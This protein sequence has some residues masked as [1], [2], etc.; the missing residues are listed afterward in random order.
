[1]NGNSIELS[2]D[3]QE[4]KSSWLSVSGKF[5]ELHPH[6]FPDL[7]PAS[8]SYLRNIP[9]DGDTFIRIRDKACERKNDVH[10]LSPRKVKGEG[11]WPT[12]ASGQDDN[13]QGRPDAATISGASWLFASRTFA[14]PFELGAFF[15]RKQDN[16]PPL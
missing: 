13:P 3:N 7:P 14:F 8:R 2:P 1:M 15:R 10:V 5:K 16:R 11:R 9:A 4:K 12:S 6:T